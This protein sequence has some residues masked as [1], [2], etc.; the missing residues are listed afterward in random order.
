M[1]SFTKARHL[2]QK[3]SDAAVNVRIIHDVL[4]TITNAHTLVGFRWVD[5]KLNVSPD[6]GSHTRELLDMLLPPF[7]KSIQV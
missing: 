7:F 6:I 3:D 2:E 5:P 4:R 1:S